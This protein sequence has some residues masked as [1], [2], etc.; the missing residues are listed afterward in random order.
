MNNSAFLAGLQAAGAAEETTV[1]FWLQLSAKVEIRPLHLI[2][3]FFFPIPSDAILYE[4]H[5]SVHFGGFISPLYAGFIWIILQN[6]CC[7]FI[8]AA[9]YVVTVSVAASETRNVS[10]VTAWVCMEV[11]YS[12]K[13]DLRLCQLIHS[14]HCASSLS[15]PR[16]SSTTWR[17][18]RLQA[19]Q[20]QAPSRPPPP[21]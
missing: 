20:T 10:E 8:A 7:S 2:T 4:R 21:R 3:E 11:K 14:E 12:N 19:T 15:S 13:D 5:K 17:A 1:Q 18:A 16:S 9:Y 6:Q